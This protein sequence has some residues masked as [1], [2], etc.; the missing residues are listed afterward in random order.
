MRSQLLLI[1]AG[2]AVALVAAG[3]LPS[4][5]RTGGAGAISL[6]DVQPASQY[7]LASLI[8]Y[9]GFAMIAMLAIAVVTLPNPTAVWAGVITALMGILFAIASI[10]VSEE[11]STD[12]LA[13]SIGP[14]EFFYIAGCLVTVAAGIVAVRSARQFDPAD[15]V[16][17]Y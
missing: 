14:G 11:L 16:T 2:L 15:P 17:G 8:F 10:I 12:D 3:E 1:L 5:W 13:R 7:F 9:G 4:W 6:H